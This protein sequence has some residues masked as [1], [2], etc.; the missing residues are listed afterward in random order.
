MSERILDKYTVLSAYS[1]NK[2][3]EWQSLEK[4]LL[5]IN[6]AVLGLSISFFTNHTEGNIRYL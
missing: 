1:E 4:I 2:K 6:G 5:T 3:T